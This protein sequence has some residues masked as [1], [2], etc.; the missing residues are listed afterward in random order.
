MIGYV[1]DISRFGMVSK[2]GR[3]GAWHGGGWEVGECQRFRRAE[4]ANEA[5]KESGGIGVQ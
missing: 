3:G 5:A 2:M 1:G 4:K